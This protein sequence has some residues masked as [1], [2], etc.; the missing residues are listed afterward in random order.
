MQIPVLSWHLHF[1]CESTT[2]LRTY[3]DKLR[4]RVLRPGDEGNPYIFP[5]QGSSDE[6]LHQPYKTLLKR[7]TRLL[8]RHVGI[9]INPH[10]Y[11]H[12]VGW[13]WLKDSPDHL[14]QV[15]RL[16]GHTSIQTT[17]NYYAEIDETL[18]VEAWRR[19]GPEFPTSL[20]LR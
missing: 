14:P 13:I 17:Q 18:A 9:K 12:L 19:G 20:P 1:V 8:A 15:Q 4:P 10:L 5:G 16:L 6:G 2:L 11:R 3:L 7:T